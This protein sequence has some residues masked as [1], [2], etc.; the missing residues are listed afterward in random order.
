MPKRKAPSNQK[1]PTR[2]YSKSSA[3]NAATQQ[4]DVVHPH[5]VEQYLQTNAMALK[6]LATAVC[7]ALGET[8]DHINSTYDHDNAEIEEI[9]DVI[10]ILE[11]PG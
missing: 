3:K 6:L 10:T 1:K 4:D 5:N 11:R 7:F 9:D 8:I 2:R